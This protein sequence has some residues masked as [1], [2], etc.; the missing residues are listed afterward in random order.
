MSAGVSRLAQRSDPPIGPGVE[1]GVAGDAGSETPEI[2]AAVGQEALL[3]NLDASLRVHGRPHFFSWTQGLLQN[4][5]NHEVLICALADADPLSFTVDCFAMN[6]REPETV[7]EDFLRDEALA[8]EFAKQWEERRFRPIVCQLDELTSLV[9]ARFARELAR[10]GVTSL[11]V[12]GTCNRDGR[13]ESLFIFACKPG[14]DPQ[15]Q[16]YVAQ[17][18]VPSLHAAYVRTRMTAHAGR[19]DVQKTTKTAPITAREQEILGWIYRGK[20]N[21]EIGAILEIS[22]L[23]IK[24]HVQKILRKLNVVNRAQAVGKA[25]DLQILKM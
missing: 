1:R 14:A 5:I 17:L 3:L 9:S 13:A 2:L 12:H 25:L 10:I 20:S 21:F 16:S 6:V 18:I 7:S 4:L 15:R 22:P 24:N 19:S 23:T 11:V 8:R